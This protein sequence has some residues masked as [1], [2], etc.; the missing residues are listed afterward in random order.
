[1]HWGAIIFSIIQISSNQH[2]LPILNKIFYI[3]LPLPDSKINLIQKYKRN[4]HYWNV[5]CNLSEQK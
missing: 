4:Q 5:S 3:K 1:M 2:I